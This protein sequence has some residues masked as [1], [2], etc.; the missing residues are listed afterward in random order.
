M[1]TPPP[2][3]ARAALLALL[4]DG[5]RVLEIGPFTKPMKRGPNMRYFDVLD[6]E[7]LIARAQEKNYKFDDAPEIHF[8]SPIGD[9]SVVDE[10]FDACL[11]SH[12]IEHQPDLIAHLE[13]VER[14]L[15]DGGRYLLV[16]PDK[17][18]C[19]DHFIPETTLADIVDAR[20]RKVHTLANVIRHRYLVTHNEPPRHWRGDNG[21]P[22]G[23]TQLQHIRNALSEFEAAGGGYV[24]V[25]AWQFTPTSFRNVMTDL[26]T[27]ELSRLQ[28]EMVY[29]TPYGTFE[30][31]AVLRK[32][33]PT[34]PPQPVAAAKPEAVEPPQAPAPPSG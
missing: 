12:S 21:F 25:H 2:E 29:G 4:D 24:D 20:G 30:F 19:F 33:V 11:S 8:V 16:I 15:E 13:Q 27:L 10:R 14:L 9:L 34:A 5:D 18:Y 22:R 28:C 7:G 6:R 23:F 17:R 31:C 26:A 3:F 1:K 32:P